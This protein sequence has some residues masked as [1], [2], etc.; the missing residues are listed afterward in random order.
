MKPKYAP[1]STVFVRTHRGLPD[2]PV[3][4]CC[5]KATVKGY[6]FDDNGE[7]LHYLL[8]GTNPTQTCPDRAEAF[9]LYPTFPDFANAIQKEFEET[10]TSLTKKLEATKETSKLVMGEDQVEVH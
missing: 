2:K 7:V 6:W 5:V 8:V 9:L 3:S 1:N 4:K 10:I